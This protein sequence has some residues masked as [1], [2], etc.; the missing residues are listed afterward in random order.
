M[1]RKEG[2]RLGSE[3]SVG[4]GIHVWKGWSGDKL[5]ENK[6]GGFNTVIHM[7]PDCKRGV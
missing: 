7:G 2:P 1:D 3:R 6:G 5:L 4:D